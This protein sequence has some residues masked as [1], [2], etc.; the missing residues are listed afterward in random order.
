MILTQRTTPSCQLDSLH[1]PWACP[2]EL[3]SSTVLSLEA[4]LVFGVKLGKVWRPLFLGFVWV[5]MNCKLVASFGKPPQGCFQHLVTN[6]CCGVED[7]RKE[8]RQSRRARGKM[9]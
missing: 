5:V 6:L 9:R 7:S 4:E 3:G 1:P 8:L 2:L